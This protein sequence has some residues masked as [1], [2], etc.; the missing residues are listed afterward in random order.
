MDC[1]SR[2]ALLG[3]N[4]CGKSTLIKLMVGALRPNRGG[5]VLKD[6]AAKIEYV[7]QHQLEQLDPM[8]SPLET[9]QSRYPGNGSDAHRQVLRSHLARF[10]LGGDLL[11]HQKILTL[12]GVSW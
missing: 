9:M 7:A 10:G 6:G 5:T 12:S 11:P 4:G 2:I 1:K 8:A 3:R